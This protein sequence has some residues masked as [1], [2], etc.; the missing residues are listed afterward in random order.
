MLF[1]PITVDTFLI[2]L[3]FLASR[4]AA[5]IE[6]QRFSY[7]YTEHTTHRILSRC[8]MLFMLKMWKMTKCAFNNEKIALA[9]FLP[10]NRFFPHRDGICSRKTDYEAGIAWF[11]FNLATSLA[12]APCVW[13]YTRNKLESD[14]RDRGMWPVGENR[15]VAMK[16]EISGF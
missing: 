12:G 14:V 5:K 13:V 4:W 8:R 6:S 3:P 2:F 7:N 11:C 10:Q 9:N 15:F 16:F 1:K